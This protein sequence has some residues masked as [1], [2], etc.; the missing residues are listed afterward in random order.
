MA[1]A[2]RIAD[3]LNA[4]YFEG[5]WTGPNLFSLLEGVDCGM[6]TKK[7]EGFNSIAQLVFHLNYYIHEQNHFFR[8]GE[9]KAKDAL[10]FDMPPIKDETEWQALLAGVKEDG[11][12]WQKHVSTLT[13]NQLAAPFIDEKYGTYYRNLHGAIQ[14]AHYHMGQIALIKK[15]L[16]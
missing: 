5:N 15:Q 12:K 16:L 7:L 1:T 3:M 13:D 8:T 11:M 6:A 4:A 14:H 10:S 9:L 2:Q